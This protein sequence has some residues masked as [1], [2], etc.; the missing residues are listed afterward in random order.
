MANA[1]RLF[2][3]IAGGIVA[4]LVVVTLGDA[5]AGAIHPLPP[6]LD[7]SDRDAV[8]TAIAGMPLAAYLALVAGWSAAGGLGAWTAARTAPSHRRRA[9]LVVGALLLASTLANLVMI[10]HPAWM[11]PA[12]LVAVA[13]AG[14]AG[15]R[16]GATGEVPAMRPDAA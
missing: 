14:V 10:P 3:S 8:R 16:L 12:A 4:A 13:L 11:W 9:G 1:F 5:L 6:G 2:L 7:F 15:A